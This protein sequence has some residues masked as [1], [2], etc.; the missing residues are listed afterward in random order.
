MD[1]EVSDE[2]EKRRT[3]RRVGD[4]VL[5]SN[6]E[7]RAGSSSG[8]S[9]AKEKTSPRKKNFLT[10]DE[11]FEAAIRASMQESAPST[12]DSTRQASTSTSSA[13]VT[14]TASKKPN[15]SASKSQAGKGRGESEEDSELEA[16]LL[17]SMASLGSSTPEVEED[18]SPS[19]E[20]LRR[21]RLARFG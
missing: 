2:S 5:P 12:S 6:G 7:Y 15:D 8:S 9:N 14:T 17:A 13:T 11:E 1:D 21:R 19:V 4:L 18:D 20:E 3:R 16:A 10:E